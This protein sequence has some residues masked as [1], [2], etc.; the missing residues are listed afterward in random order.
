[1]T[2]YFKSLFATPVMT[3][4]QI[5][6]FCAMISAMICFQQKDRK[7]IL[8]WQ[9]IL[10]VLWTVHFIL[11]NNPT[12][13]ALNASQVIRSIIY[14][15]KDNHNWAQSKLWPAVFV[16]IALA[17]GI[18][19]WNGPL[20][21]L[22]IIGTTIATISVWMNNPF[23]IRLLSIPVSVTWGIYDLLSKSIAGFCNELFTLISI[24]TAIFR[25]DLK[26][27]KIKK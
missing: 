19:T 13:A 8:M 20:S 26:N 9:I 1:M 11:L 21:I 10:T 3:V 6:G 7:R 27:R 25:I 23:T 18:I 17:I 12:G 24:I 14:Y 4:S 5:I 2:D 16:A 15:N 22:P